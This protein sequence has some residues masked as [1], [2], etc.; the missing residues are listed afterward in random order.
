[1]FL[2]IIYFTVKN[3]D[4]KQKIA[5]FTSWLQK[6]FGEN[7]GNSCVA[8]GDAIVAYSGAL[9]FSVYKCYNTKGYYVLIYLLTDKN[10]GKKAVK[11]L[12]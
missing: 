3:C 4:S 12:Y 10:E 7:V 1:V 9:L 11:K 5:G 8:S 2:Q 6:Y